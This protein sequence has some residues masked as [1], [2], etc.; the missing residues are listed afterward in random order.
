MVL[1]CTHE[2]NITCIWT[3]LFVGHMVGSQPMKRKKK[4]H[5]I[6]LYIECTVFNGK[7]NTDSTR[8]SHTNYMK[9]QSGTFSISL[10]ARTLM[11]SFPAFL[12]TVYANSQLSTC[13]ADV[14]QRKYD[15]TKIL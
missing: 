13:T 10:V 15:S 5:Q 4:I 7:N 14:I 3:Q 11:M 2:Q 12:L 9:E 8:K 6:I 1:Q